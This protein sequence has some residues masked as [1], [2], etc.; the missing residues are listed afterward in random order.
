LKLPLLAVVLGGAAW[1]SV[2][3][4]ANPFALVGGV[5]LV[6]AVMFLKAIGSL[7]V[8]RQAAEPARMPAPW[9][10]AEHWR[11]LA[12]GVRTRPDADTRSRAARDRRSGE[13][14][15]AARPDPLPAPE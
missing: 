6:Q 3:Q 9:M 10:K 7:L 12:A 15:W 2:Q 11:A 8:S 13:P 4:I 14:A 5:A 1:M